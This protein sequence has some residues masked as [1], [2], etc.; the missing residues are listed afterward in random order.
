[1]FKKG[2]QQMVTFGFDVQGLLLRSLRGAFGAVQ[3]QKWDASRISRC[4]RVEEKTRDVYHYL[5]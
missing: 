5:S 1:M 4:V 2:K 3:G